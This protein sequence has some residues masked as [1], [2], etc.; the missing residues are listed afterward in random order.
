[1]WCQSSVDQ[2]CSTISALLSTAEKMNDTY[3]VKQ[4]QKKHMLSASSC[5]IKNMKFHLRLREMHTLSSSRTFQSWTW[6]S[7]FKSDLAEMC[8]HSK[9][10]SKSWTA[11]A[12]V[13]SIP[14]DAEHSQRLTWLW[15][16]AVVFIF[17][18]TE[19]IDENHAGHTNVESGMIIVASSYLTKKPL[20]VSG[21]S[22]FSKIWDKRLWAGDLR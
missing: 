1:M 22:F 5:C 3:V 21:T 18:F 16:V 6:R 10:L 15:L 4:K 13:V 14:D 8:S 2:F 20:S 12:E 19:L 7:K 11:L 9:K 17:I